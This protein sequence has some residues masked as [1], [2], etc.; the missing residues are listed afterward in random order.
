MK[1]T[2]ETKLKAGF[3]TFVLLAGLSGLLIGVGFAIGGPQ[4]ALIF[5]LI[6]LAIN[7]FSYFF[8]D[9][10]ALRMSRAKPVSREED[11]Q[12]YETVERLAQKTGVPMPR[13]YRIPSSQANAFATGRNPKHGAVAVTDGI[14]K[15]LTPAELE[16][17][18]AHELAHIK[19]YDILIGSIAAAIGSAITY[20]GYMAL[21]F[22]DSNGLFSLIAQL[23]IWLLAPLAAMIIQMAVSRQREYA[24]DAEGAAICGNPESLASA[25]MRL[26]QSVETAPMQVNQ[27]QESMYI[28]KPFRAAG[29]AKLFST[30]PPT[31]DRIKRLREMR[32]SL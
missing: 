14:T 5:L 7:F 24:A 18:I 28:V 12:L 17:V 32:P 4:T 8:S 3:K 10:L 25:L 9:K 26:E 23:L 27:A 16:G 2:R 15:L 22:S 1:T 31:E 20:L 19:H 30:H 6:S 29:V 11:P 21:W 13:L